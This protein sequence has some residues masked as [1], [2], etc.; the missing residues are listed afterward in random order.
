MKRRTIT[1]DIYQKIYNDYINGISLEELCQKY[2]F[3]KETIEKHL[4]KNGV[5]LSKTRK[6]SKEELE[7][8]IYDYKNGLKP[9]ELATKYNRNSGT[10]I[11]KLKDAGEY[12]FSK[13][14][15]SDEEIEFLK[16]HYPIRDWESIRNFLPN[17]SISSIH[18]KMHSLGIHM[19]SFYWDK[20][21]IE[22]L[23]STYRYAHGKINEL[24]KVFNGKFTYKAIISKARR[25]GLKTRELWSNSEITILKRYYSIKTLDEIL[26][27]LPNKSRKSIIYKAGKLGLKNSCKYQ[28]WEIQFIID[29]WKNMSDANLAQSLGKKPQSIGQKRCSLGLLRLKEKSSY[30]DLSEYIRR[31]N[32][33]WKVLSM[34]NCKYK[35]VLTGER[36]DDIHHLYGLNLIL[37]ETLKE[38]CIDIK[39]DINKYTDKELDDILNLFRIN[40]SKYP[41]GVCL[42]KTVHTLFHNMYGYGNNTPNQWDEFVKDFKNKNYE[43]FMFSE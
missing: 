1:E 36:F 20:N 28:N 32:N 4:R 24:V 43:N 34:A 3:K 7:N 30:N 6:F 42:S 41:L 26:T 12:K 10:I 11:G 37:N 23:I 8:I 31:N 16:I 35:C 21:D 18:N 19:D 33:E 15:F 9:Y 25:L 38:L 17:V 5:C 14:H 2:D 29:N 22:L 27:L 13:H 39:D 40:Q